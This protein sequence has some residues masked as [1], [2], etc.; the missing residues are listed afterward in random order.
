[1]EELGV[2]QVLAPPEAGGLRFPLIV[3]HPSGYG[4]VGMTKQ[5]KVTNEAELRQQVGGQLWQG[6]RTATG[7]CDAVGEGGL[8]AEP[9]VRTESLETPPIAPQADAGCA[10][11]AAVVTVPR[12][13]MVQIP[14]VCG[15]IG[16]CLETAC[17]D[18]TL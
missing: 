16:C 8:D 13:V 14:F 2:A 17:R 7:S 12:R 10:G 3:K 6:G 11:I 18:W 5:S 15:H 4:S 1:M 9:P